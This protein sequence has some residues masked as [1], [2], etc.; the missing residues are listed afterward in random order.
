MKR[1]TS[2]LALSI[3][4]FS[5]SFAAESFCQSPEQG[6]TIEFKIETPKLVLEEVPFGFSV[7]ATDSSGNTLRGFAAEAEVSGFDLSETESAPGVAHKLT[8]VNGRAQIDKAVIRHSGHQRI[9]VRF[10]G[11]A[12]NRDVRVIPGILSLLP[13]L[14]AIVLAFAARQ[15]LISLFCGIWLGA[16]F[17]NDYNFFVGFMR[18]IDTYVVKAISDTSRASIL[19]FSLT[20]GGMVGVIS[21]SGGTQGIVDKLT[22]LAKNARGGQIAT[23]AMGLFIFFDDYANTLIVG[24]TMRPFTDKLRISREKLSYIVDSTAAPVA[25]I[26]IVSTWVGFQVG[27]IDQAFSNLDLGVDAYN[28]FLQSIPHSTYS[29]LALIF[30]LFIALTKRDFGPMLRAERRASD[31][32]KVLADG[33]RPIADSATLDM[34]ASEDTPKRWYNAMIPIVLVIGITVVGLYVDGKQT[35]GAAA[36]EKTLGEIFGAANSF[37]ILMWASFTGL[38]VA[39][40]LAVGQRLLS[41]NEAVEAAVSGYKS[42][43]LAGM[44]LVLAWSI[45]DMCKDLRTA[46]FVI[47]VSKGILSPHLIPVI[48]F[49]VAA[50]ISFSTGSSWATMAILT[51]IVV[52]IAHTLPIEAGLPAGLDYEILIGTIGA[53]LSGSVLGDHC[54][55][56]SD[57]TILSSMASAADHVDHVKTQLPYAAVVGGVGCLVGYLPNGWGMNAYVSLGLGTILLFIIVRF[58]GKLDSS[59]RNQA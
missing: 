42:M 28:A 21:R 12:A 23:W 53:I 57:T 4:A 48:T 44:I 36:A 26:A 1:S 5:L 32:G 10:D 51:P 8:F 39:S 3:L 38:F 55:P 33:A 14:L 45:G 7:E 9:S 37:N 24:N 18:T 56:I 15:V 16:L 52:P 46:D 19:L 30:V 59:E 50:F 22:K 35:L 31:E 27:L 47:S 13:P 41:L 34:A 11:R 29:I 20:L 58:F 43:V 17:I 54:S 40:L 6:Q 2:V 25:S 49:I